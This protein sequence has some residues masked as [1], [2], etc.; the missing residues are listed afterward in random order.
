MKKDTNCCFVLSFSPQAPR[1]TGGLGS[2]LSSL[3]LAD[4]FVT[5]MKVKSCLGKSELIEETGPQK[6]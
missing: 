1:G 5:G 2:S 4:F 6:Y 3:A